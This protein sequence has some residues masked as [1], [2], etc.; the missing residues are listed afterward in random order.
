MQE[1]T[2]HAVTQLLDAYRTGDT[3]ALRQLLPLV[4]QELHELARSQRRKN[5]SSPTINTTALVH[6][7]YLRLA[8][9]PNAW[10]GRR[11]FFR[12]AARAMRHILIDYARERR[13]QKRGGDA[14]N[15]SLD[16]LGPVAMD[17]KQAEE[18]I[19]I[20]EALERLASVDPRMVEVVELRYFGGFTIEETAATLDLSSATIKRDWAT[21][22]MWLRAELS[23]T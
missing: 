6:E 21:A 12:V 1:S 2:P 17:D 18:M 7:A 14:S 15:L 11:H 3:G 4:Y 19:A 16:D 20:H 10:E 9:K 23:N 13:A 22:R 8:D 5:P